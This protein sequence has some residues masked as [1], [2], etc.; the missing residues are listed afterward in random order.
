MGL[1]NQSHQHHLP[2]VKSN[3]AQP[4]YDFICIILKVSFQKDQ[5]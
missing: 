3:G 5:L 2:C 4:L 1:V